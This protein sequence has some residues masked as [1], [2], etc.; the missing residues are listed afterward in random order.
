MGEHED[1]HNLFESFRH[2]KESAQEHKNTAKLQLKQ[3]ANQYMKAV[4]KLDSKD[5]NVKYV[6]ASIE[7]LL[8]AIDTGNIANI[9]RPIDLI[10]KDRINLPHKPGFFEWLIG[11]R[12]H[13]KQQRIS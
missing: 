1:W 12:K 8:P 9:A 11:S 3:M 4:Q 5:Q 6:L 2:F 7:E 13:Y 10:G